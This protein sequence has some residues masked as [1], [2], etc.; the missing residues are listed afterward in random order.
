MKIIAFI[1]DDALF[2]ICDD[3]CLSSLEN[4]DK[5]ICPIPHSLNLHDEIIFKSARTQKP[6]SL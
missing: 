2:N 1:E 4:E 3:I 6:W 5:H